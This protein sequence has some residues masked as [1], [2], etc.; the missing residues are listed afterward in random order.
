MSLIWKKRRMLRSETVHQIVEMALKKAK[1]QDRVAD[2]LP[3]ISQNW[4]LSVSYTH[5]TL[6]TTCQV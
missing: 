4:C 1:Y 3:Q 5:L 6:P 2:L